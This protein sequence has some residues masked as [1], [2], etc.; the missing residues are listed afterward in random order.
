M[1]K[2]SYRASEVIDLLVLHDASLSLGLHLPKLRRRLPLL[3]QQR[4]HARPW[5][6]AIARRFR[7][8][9]RRWRRCCRGRWRRDAPDGRSELRSGGVDGRGVVGDRGLRILLEHSAAGRRLI[10]NMC[11]S[12]RAAVPHSLSIYLGWVRGADKF[13]AWEPLIEPSKPFLLLFELGCT[14]R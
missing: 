6:D 3:R 13:R 10:E 2:N 9:R 7:G 12:A 4:R 8:R 5:G 14:L 1:R 11:G